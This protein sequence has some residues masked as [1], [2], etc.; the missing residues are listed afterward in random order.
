MEQDDKNGVDD[1]I[2]L[3]RLDDDALLN[4]LRV[5]YAR[6]NIYVHSVSYFSYLFS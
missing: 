2:K 1:M 3:N 5:R 6:D 4:N